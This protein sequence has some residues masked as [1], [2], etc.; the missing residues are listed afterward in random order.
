MSAAPEIMASPSRHWRVVRDS[1]GIVWLRFDTVGRGVN[2]LSRDT[3]D[4]LERHLLD[5]NGDTFRGLVILSDKE[6]GFIA[7]ADVE[8]LARLQSEEESLAYVRRAH[9]VLGR[10][11][12]LPCP[13]VAAI[14]GFCLGG[15]LELALACRHRVAE[16]D[17]QTRL[18]L[19][20]VRLGIHPG[21]GGT[22]R[23]PRLIGAVPAL[24]TML[25][26]R[27]VDARSAYRMGLVD[28]PPPRRHMEA[29]ARALILRRPREKSPTR[30]EKVRG[31]RP[32]RQVTAALA[33]RRL[34]KSVRPEHYPAP[35]ALLDLWAGQ[36]SET[37]VAL[38]EEATSVAH[39][40][41]GDA[42]R[43]LVRVFLLRERL[44]SLAPNDLPPP[45]HIHVVGAGA[46]G[47]DI[48][49]WCALQGLRVTLQDREAQILGPAV[50]RA[51]ALFRKR[52]RT[53]REVQAAADRLVP[54]PNG[55][56]LKRAELVIE[57]IF[58]DAAAKTELYRTIEPRMRPEAVLATNTS[59]IPLEDLAVFLE[60]PQR[61]VG[62]HF[63]NPVARMP[64][65]EV[66]SG[67]AT[68]PASTRLALALTRRIN[69]APLPVRSCPGF[70]VNRILL[71]YLLEAVALVEEGFRAETVDRAAVDFGFPVGPL[72]LADAVGLDV[73]LSVA[74]V[75][76]ERMG[77]VLPPLLQSLVAAGRLGR[78]A[79]RGFY[80]HPAR[81]W[82][83]WP[84]HSPDGAAEICDR[85][86]LPLLNEAVACLDEKVVEDADLVDAG[87]VLGAGFAPFRGGPL[88]YARARGTAL[89]KARLTDLAERYGQRFAP[90]SAWGRI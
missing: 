88:H 43:N 54:D 24:H 27:A 18:G 89:V 70:L 49:A 85:L 22:V 25:S 37:R 60:R 10:L 9:E 68:H 75:L 8:E 59:S 34:R 73:C 57:A 76:R 71:P 83:F 16:D 58:E 45:R 51:Y 40:A 55:T 47:G 36:S 48:G 46:M 74:K 62:M 6:S 15:G 78:K 11:E 17:P 5:L 29:A 35:Y 26:G 79:G 66:A 41:G 31:A 30:W 56:G 7:G 21:F 32:L 38:A 4:E 84:T 50:Q 69:R 86:V 20:E 13:T 14:H 65:V 82:R 52:L 77:F 19:P 80:R 23:L 44:K 67:A 72:A 2:V 81:S 42:A 61:L 33:R 1:E 64:L 53:D 28:R 63:F 3:L 90:H 39:L 87:V 12:G